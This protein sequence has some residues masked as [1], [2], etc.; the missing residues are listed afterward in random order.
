MFD[1]S[2]YG[3]I[4]VENSPYKLKAVHGLDS[5]SRIIGMLT[6]NMVIGVDMEGEEEKAALWYSQDDDNVKYS[7]K[8]RRGWQIAIPS[9]IVKYANS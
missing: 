9:E 2:T 5:T 1:A 3:E 4:R 7:F 8:F 6:S